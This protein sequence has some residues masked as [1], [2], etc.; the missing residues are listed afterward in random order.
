MKLNKIVLF[1][2]STLILYGCA[3]PN[4]SDSPASK[5]NLQESNGTV[6]ATVNGNVLEVTEDNVIRVKVARPDQEIEKGLKLNPDGI[7]E[8][9]LAYINLPN[10]TTDSSGNVFNDMLEDWLV[11]ENVTFEIIESNQAILRLVDQE[12]S[13]QETLVQAGLAFVPQISSEKLNLKKLEETAQNT[14]VGI[15]SLQ[16]FE[17]NTVLNDKIGAGVAMITEDEIY[18]LVE[19]LDITQS[20]ESTF[21]EKL[22]NLKIRSSE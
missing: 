7:M 8:I 19:H 5:E 17:K 22:E 12:I 15:W 16:E 14:K 3:T 4:Y 2:I 11:Q 21:M 20:L 13:V 10:L 18:K 6:L 1:L 9:S